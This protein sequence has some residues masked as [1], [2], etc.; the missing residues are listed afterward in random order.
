MATGTRY[1]V[2]HLEAV[3]SEELPYSKAILL[4]GARQVGKT[5]LLKKLFPSIPVVTFDPVID[6]MQA[7]SNPDLF[8]DSLP[9]PVILDEVQYAPEIFAPLKRRLDALSENGKYLLTGSQNPMLLKQVSESMAGRVR[10]FTLE[11]YSMAERSRQMEMLPWFARF[12]DCGGDWRKTDVATNN[13]E[14]ESLMETLWR[15][16]L[17]DA[18]QLPL[19]MVGRYISSYVQTYLER[20]VRIS[21]GAVDVD[22]FAVFLGLC[23][24]L[25]A[26][27]INKAQIGREIGIAPATAE[28]WLAVLKATFQWH[29]LR[30]WQG[31]VVK[32]L[33][34]K[35]KGIMADT[36][37]MAHL[38]RLS[39]PEALLS[40]PQRGAI[41]ESF[42]ANEIRK[43]M[44][45]VPSVV[46]QYHWRT[47]GGA[48]VDNVL[49]VDGRLHP[50]EVK[51][52]DHLDAY[53]LR[54]IRAFRQ[55]YGNL[56]ASGAIV[57]AGHDTYW[58]DECTLAIPWNAV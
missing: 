13:H 10:I 50:F 23:A 31:N 53:D 19:K 25:S 38:L 17:P 45:N 39:S 15:G 9:T 22:K 40:S 55:T 51:C 57:Y 14:S 21:G 2:R 8:L 58:L 37:I 11:S 36:G 44:F 7:R 20:D 18:V 29:E 3:I 24:A 49:A 32:R 1:K 56:A 26:Q 6:I 28:K 12:L 54:G 52:K 41:F 27:E 33:S 4:I 5:T 35:S 30:P 46:E 34:G 47:V 43:Q 48:E 42:V 16:S